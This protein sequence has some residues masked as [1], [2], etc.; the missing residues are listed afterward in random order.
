MGIDQISARVI[1]GLLLITLLTALVLLVLTGRRR[2]ITIA[3]ISNGTGRTD[4]NDSMADASV[5]FRLNVGTEL[6]NVRAIVLDYQNKVRNVPDRS[7]ALTLPE[8]KDA[9]I[10]NQDTTLASLL[11]SLEAGPSEGFAAQFQALAQLVTRSRGATV[12]ATVY[13]PDRNGDRLRIAVEVV[14]PGSAFAKRRLLEAAEPNPHLTLAERIDALIQPAAR[15]AAID[16]AAWVLQ[17][18]KRFPVPGGG[19][20]RSGLAHNMA[21]LLMQVSAD[22]FGSFAEYFLQFA[23]DEFK[24]A[25]AK[26]PH[27]YQPHFNL[28]T[29][30]EGEAV[31]AVSRDQYSHFMSA[32]SEYRAAEQTAGGIADPAGTTIQ[33]TI[34]IRLVRAELISDVPRLRDEALRWLRDQRL[35]VD[36]DCCFKRHRRPWPIRAIRPGQDEIVLDKLTADYL[37]NSACMYAI[38]AGMTRRADWDK[39]SRRLL[40]TALVIDAGE[41]DLWDLV[42]NDSDLKPLSWHLPEFLAV[43]RKALPDCPAEEVPLPEIVKLVDDARTAAGWHAGPTAAARAGHR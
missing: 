31:A 16:L 21:G 19:R 1:D 15:C 41:G 11:T 17:R 34:R 6:E 8:M 32:V 20:R 25:A 23:L 37:Y 42:S 35:K 14:S 3:D 22:R 18:P 24:A 38:A 7:Y 9:L 4:L 39:H 5:S 29:T 13:L 30:Q 40:G 33:R 27:D 2:H 43:L 26:L 28:A 10:A 36:L 12:T